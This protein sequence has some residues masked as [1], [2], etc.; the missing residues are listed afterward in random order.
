MIFIYRYY[1]MALS[2]NDFHNILINNINSNN[3]YFLARIGGSDF[4]VVLDFFYN[5][6]FNKIDLI[7]ND[8]WFDKVVISVSNLNGYFDKNLSREE[9]KH[10]FREYVYL[11]YDCYA[12]S[13]SFSLSGSTIFE[14]NNKNNHKLNFFLNHVI[15]N[16]NLVS[17]GFIEEAYPFLNSFKIFAENK[18]ILVIS[19]FSYYVEEQFKNKDKLINNYEYPNFNLITYNTPI[20]YNTDDRNLNYMI[21]NCFTS[22]SKLMCSEI[23]NIDF[24]IALLSCGSYAMPIG[25]Y[26]SNKLNKKAIYIGGMLNVLFNIYGKRYD[27]SFFNNIVNLNYQVKVDNNVYMHVQGGK[28][29]NNE[30]LYAYF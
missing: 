13:N 26:I 4:N 18:K 30:A 7:Y 25:N 14:T 6:Y 11:M 1:I 10:N 3:N 15:P 12:N 8:E 2:Y 23:N 29:C 5:L 27:T 17:Y 28:I 9:R 20:T 21:Q 16:K 22:Q 24:D 19:P